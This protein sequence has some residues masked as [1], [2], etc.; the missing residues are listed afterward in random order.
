L[1]VTTETREQVG[2]EVTLECGCRLEDCSLSLNG[3][4]RMH[5]TRS[6]LAADRRQTAYVHDTKGDMWRRN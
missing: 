5:A 3:Q 4:H 1:T 2:R 6:P